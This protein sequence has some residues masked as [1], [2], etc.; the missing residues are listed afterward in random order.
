MSVQRR[1][2]LLCEF[3]SRLDGVVLECSV[4]T[5]RRNFHVR[6][7]QDKT[8]LFELRATSGEKKAFCSSHRNRFFKLF[9]VNHQASDLMNA[10]KKEVSER[11]NRKAQRGRRQ[12]R[13]KRQRSR[14]FRSD[15]ASVDEEDMMSIGS[16]ESRETRSTWSTKDNR[17]RKRSGRARPS[18]PVLIASTDFHAVDLPSPQNGNMESLEANR[19]F[20]R[21]AQPVMDIDISAV[22]ERVNEF[23]QSL[24]P[25]NFLQALAGDHINE[26]H[27]NA[28]QTGINSAVSTRIPSVI[29][30]TAVPKLGSR[31][32]S[33]PSCLQA[34]L[35]FSSDSNVHAT[36]L[37]NP[38]LQPF[39]DP[40]VDVMFRF[41][42]R[43]QT[44]SR[45]STRTK[46][47]S[48]ALEHQRRA[49]M[50]PE[51]TKLLKFIGMTQSSDSEGPDKS[52]EVSRE[53]WATYQLLEKA[54]SKT[55]QQIHRLKAIVKG[56]FPTVEA[57]HRRLNVLL[58][59]RSPDTQACE[60][61]KNI[62]H[63]ANQLESRA[64]NHSSAFGA[65]PL[66]Q[67]ADSHQLQQ[68][69]QETS[70]ILGHLLG[71]GA[72][73][74]EQVQDRI[75]QLTSGVFKIDTESVARSTSGKLKVFVR[76]E[77]KRL[78]LHKDIAS[79]YARGTAPVN[80]LE[81]PSTAQILKQFD[82]TRR[83]YSREA[84]ASVREKR[85]FDGFDDMSQNSSVAKVSKCDPESF[86][87]FV[88]CVGPD[89]YVCS[90]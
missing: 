62:V 72:Y 37:M 65:E 23:C 29:L 2:S 43:S 24:G 48:H 66:S 60:A 8:C 63:R 51:D 59:P 38:R 70:R 11:M 1:R 33:K 3:C 67:L 34:A 27:Q 15:L 86:L 64:L 10:T 22:W 88:T 36:I 42:F 4:G 58:D 49:K 85:K 84:L 55:R 75:K 18:Q 7:G 20:Q 79:G 57:L 40:R 31:A 46:D 56:Q 87:L 47:S 25:G 45:L 74:D 52:T 5:C 77:E 78:G 14:P 6:C 44:L 41:E 61:V 71:L 35:T 80:L 16:K 17:L 28:Q 83:Q 30:S 9:M 69:Q 73:P 13:V 81:K 90:R 82:F 50:T 89:Q 54:Q 68:I 12:L 32:T 53:V 39:Y 19:G 76:S 26:G 21:K